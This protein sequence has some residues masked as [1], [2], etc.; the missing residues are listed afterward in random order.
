MAVVRW[1]PNVGSIVCLKRSAYPFSGVF[2]T[3]VKIGPVALSGKRGEL[4]V[5]AV[6]DRQVGDRIETPRVVRLAPA[7]GRIDRKPLPL[8]ERIA[9]LRRE[10]RRGRASDRRPPRR[11]ALSDD[12]GARPLRSPRNKT[13]SFWRTAAV[14]RGSTRCGESCRSRRTAS[15]SEN[16]SV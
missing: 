1:M 8:L 12:R 10:N 5:Q 6:V 11:P 13:V 7:D 3:R 4:P 2:H 14:R 9:D 16:Y 15:S